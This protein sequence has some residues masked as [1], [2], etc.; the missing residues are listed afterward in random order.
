MTNREAI[1][2]EMFERIECALDYADSRLQC[3]LG[4]ARFQA[5]A[6]CLE[7]VRIALRLL[8]A[9]RAGEVIDLEAEEAEEAERHHAE[10]AEAEA[11]N[12]EYEREVFRS[13]R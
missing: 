7:D 5:D 6:E 9:I 10:L 1:R 3:H 4:I 11:E 13:F 2:S 8:K 12:R